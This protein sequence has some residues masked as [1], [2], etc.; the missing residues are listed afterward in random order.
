MSKHK[1]V[2]LLRSFVAE[3]SWIR[4]Y[5]PPLLNGYRS[6]DYVAQCVRAEDAEFIVDCLHTLVS[7]AD[8]SDAFNASKANA[9]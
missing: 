2:Q 4:Y 8:L 7:I 9:Q 3:G 6:G 5:G 1:N